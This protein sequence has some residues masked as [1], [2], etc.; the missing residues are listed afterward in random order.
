[1]CLIWGS[2][3]LVIRVGNETVPPVWA[4]A[5]R[6]ALASV[7][8]CVLTVATRARFPRG[9]SLRGAL[10]FG[11]LNFGV[12]FSLLYWSE[13]HVPS[14]LA[15]I[16]YSTIPLSTG[17]LAWAFRL[18]RL[19]PV[20]LG[21]ALVGLL[22]VG[23]I[24][25]GE[26]SAGAPPLALL[27]VLTAATS[28]SL[29]GVFLKRAPQA[30]IPANA[31]GAALG[32]VFCFAA[33]RVLGEHQALPR[34]AAAWGPIL[35]LT[36]A[37]SLGAYLLYTWLI[38]QWPL[39]SVATGTLVIP[40]LAVALGAAA[41]G[42][43]LTGEAYLGALIVLGAVAE[44]LWLS[45]AGAARTEDGRARYAR[46]LVPPPLL[47]LIALGLGLWLSAR[48]PVAPPPSAAVRALGAAALLAAGTLGVSGVRAFRRTRTPFV[49]YLE[50]TAL[51]TDGAFR[52]TRNP[53]YLSAAGALAG[54][55]LWVSSVWLLA[56][57]PALILALTRLVVLPEERYLEERFGESY[58]AY[59]A[60]VRR[61]I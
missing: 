5:L 21:A 28:A 18:Q 50:T 43:R 47:F 6:L 27:A 9:A 58:R 46:V 56:L 12:N 31:V 3:F 32:A 55:A 1:M 52:F 44:T 16:V 22:G 54:I 11:L 49:P 4:A 13:Q 51:I 8:L 42:E 23:V 7:L 59:R 17:I 30:P 10:L 41:K 36:L 38:T 35:Y 48:W 14:G 61:W 24:F 57:L 37:G 29:S 20:Q 33:S 19:D 45:R 60:R 26:L 40:V 25:S 39:T 53:L 15:A 34:A 2:T